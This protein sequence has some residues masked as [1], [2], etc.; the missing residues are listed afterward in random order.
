MAL[1][2]IDGMEMPQ[3]TKYSFPMKDM[4]SENSYNEEGDL[5]QDRVRQGISSIDLAW[6]AN[7]E[8]AQILLSAIFPEKV[9]VTYLDPRVNDYRTAEMCVS[10]RSC[11]LTVF[12][13][14]GSDTNLWAISFSLIQY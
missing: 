5:F 9:T 11:E 1:L 3:P 8:Q 2:T 6:M 7:S 13:G 10:D 14:N 4:L 12:D